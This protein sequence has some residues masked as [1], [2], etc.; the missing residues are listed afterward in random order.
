MRFTR[1][2]INKSRI[3]DNLNEIRKYSN[4]AKIMALVKA[5]AYGH[6]MINISKILEEQSIDFLGVAYLEEAILLRKENIKSN[7]VVLVAEFGNESSY[8][9]YNLQP[10]VSSLEFLEKLE[11]EGKSRNTMIDIHVYID[12]GMSR[13]GFK[14]GEIDELISKAKKFRFINF[15]G[16]F[17]H[18]S[19][20]ATDKEFS[21]FQIN[22]FKEIISK[23]NENG[24]SFEYYHCGNSGA[25]SNLD[26]SLFNL[27]RPGLSIYGYP[28]S[29]QNLNELELKPALSLKTKILMKR[30]VL[31]G[32]P[33]SYE[34]LFIADQDSTIATLPIGYGDGF[35]KLLTHKAKCLINEKFYN[36]VGAICMD[37]CMVDLGND[38]YEIGTDV[39]L[40]G[41]SNDN[42]ITAQDL[43]DLIGT[44]PY[45]ITTAISARVE[46][47]YE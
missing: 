4:N 28:P 42:K 22:K 41:E 40:I 14:N 9:E 7:I 34:R 19:S 30:R 3:I 45:E 12:T 38:D 27:V 31:K 23:F 6:G 1:A 10:A 5:N 36:I 32:E 37:E 24:I 20:S 11:N 46:R 8:F 18:L 33:V 44:I 43:S 16:I 25:I 35:S 26:L 17:T 2:I 15:L 29:N 13:D 47:V 21:N 39:I